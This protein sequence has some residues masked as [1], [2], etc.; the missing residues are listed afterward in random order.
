MSMKADIAKRK[1]SIQGSYMKITFVKSQNSDNETYYTVL[2][3][4]S[5][6][7]ANTPEFERANYVFEQ[8]I[9]ERKEKRLTFTLEYY[10]GIRGEMTTHESMFEGASLT[11]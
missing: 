4:G 8:A 2:M 7:C 5:P 11:V 6:I 1:Q 9:K 10:D 3:N